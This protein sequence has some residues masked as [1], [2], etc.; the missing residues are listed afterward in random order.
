MKI[1]AYSRKIFKVTLILLLV[2]PQTTL[3]PA[4]VDSTTS[5]NPDPISLLIQNG[6]S[7]KY[8]CFEMIEL[9][10]QEDTSYYIP[11][12]SYKKHTN[13][14]EKTVEIF[15]VKPTQ[16]EVTYS[17]TVLDTTLPASASDIQDFEEPDTD[18]LD[19]PS[20]AD[21]AYELERSK[22]DDCWFITDPYPSEW[23]LVYPEYILDPKAFNFPD[24]SFSCPPMGT[25]S[26]TE[27]ELEEKLSTYWTHGVMT[28]T[29][30]SETK[31][32]STSVGYLDTV[33][34]TT[35][36]DYEWTESFLEN[37][38]EIVLSHSLHEKSEV[39]FEVK[40]GLMVYYKHESSY[41]RRDGNYYISN[42][43]TNEETLVNWNI[44]A[45]PIE[46][47]LDVIIETDKEGAYGVGETCTFKVTIFERGTGKP[48]N[49]VD[50]EIVATHQ[51]SGSSSTNFRKTQGNEYSWSW[52]WGQSHIG[53]W[54]IEVTA[55]KSGYHEGYSSIYVLVEWSSISGDVLEVLFMPISPEHGGYV[56]ASDQEGTIFYSHGVKDRSMP[57]DE[58]GS[59]EILCP[60]GVYTVWA[61]ATC[62][63]S[64]SHEEVDTREKPATGINFRLS[65]SLK[66]LDFIILDVNGT[67]V[68]D[69]IVNL[70]EAKLW[71]NTSETGDAW[72]Q[73]TATVLPS[74]AN[75]TLRI[76]KGAQ[77]FTSWIWIE[78]PNCQYLNSPGNTTL[79]P[80]LVLVNQTDPL[81]PSKI[82]AVLGPSTGASFLVSNLKITPLKAKLGETVEISVKVTN[83]GNEGGTYIVVLTVN[84]YDLATREIDLSPGESETVSW[85]TSD[86]WSAGRYTVEV[87]GETGSF[88]IVED[89]EAVVSLYMPSSSVKKGDSITIGG[90]VSPAEENQQI[91]IDVKGADGSWISLATVETEY[92]G[93]YSYDWEPLYTGSYQVRSVLIDQ[94]GHETVISS[95]GS[96]SVKEESKCFIAT[97]TYG[98]EL[99]PEVQ[100]LRGFRDDIVLNTFAGSNFMVLFNSWYYSFSPSVA[101]CIAGNE[102]LRGVMKVCLYPLMGILYIGYKVFSM[103]SFNSELGVVFAGLVSSVLIGAVYFGPPLL[104][105]NCRR[106]VRVSSSVSNG[107]M[108]LLLSSIISMLASEITGWATLMMM[109]SGAFVLVCM[110]VAVICLLKFWS[111][112]SVDKLKSLVKFFS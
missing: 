22:K 98:S 35:K 89:S 80:G 4:S 19:M 79:G 29:V 11:N 20:E 100:F 67:P 65:P 72:L 93:Y 56:K 10:A 85:H 112:F 87:G 77:T 68:E 14:Y 40:T 63:F 39:N 1:Q 13:S 110:G 62:Y 106:K 70:T 73:L 52:V 59:Y 46:P 66:R 54:L 17:R 82:R 95:I 50:L 16:F 27:S 58:D 32:F 97:A 5:Y 15:N 31:Y 103:F 21:I 23:L 61:W 69:A 60:P 81:A 6:T 33:K 78:F 24:I 109:S 25:R 64:E 36:Y 91:R 42:S 94:A 96:L 38:Q 8:S 43:F 108:V 12:Y 99:S 34:I 104:V 37:N 57:W 83:V 105:L 26:Y 111:R 92:D 90:Y 28:I 51:E 47:M 101:G 41:I 86:E 88:E 7:L 49:D 84:D 45:E 44:G 53:T 107:L 71:T 75:F 55:R 102:I 76:S 18:L 2:F 9:E 30:S 3:F 48:V 74:P